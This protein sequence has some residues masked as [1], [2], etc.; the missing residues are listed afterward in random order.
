MLPVPYE[1]PLAGKY[2]L[3]L[4]AVVTGDELIDSCGTEYT[5]YRKG[6]WVCGLC[7]VYKTPFSDCTKT[8]KLYQE[9]HI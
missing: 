7:Y 6:L 9:Q 3:V 4:N 1:F 8:Y 2:I 5:K